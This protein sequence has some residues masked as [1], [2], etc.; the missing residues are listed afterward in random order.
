MAAI[1]K[2]GMTTL[3]FGAITRTMIVHHQKPAPNGGTTT[4]QPVGSI[5][6]L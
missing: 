6:F 3:K 5:N 4:N 2:A 1:T